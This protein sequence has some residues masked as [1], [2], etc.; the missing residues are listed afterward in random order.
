MKLL[1]E[2]EAEISAIDWKDI[3]L[4][5]TNASRALRK[6]GSDP[7][8]LSELLMHASKD[9][10]LNELSEHYDILDKIVLGDF[11]GTGMR[12]RLHVFA[13][14]YFD[15]P[16]N[17]RWPYA[18]TILSGSYLHRIFAASVEKLEQGVEV[19]ALPVC[20]AQQLKAG[21]SYAL[22]TDVVHSITAAPGTISMIL[23]GPSQSDRFLVMDRVSNMSWWQYGRANE[24]PAQIASKRMR[25]ESFARAIDRVKLA[26]L[27]PAD[28]HL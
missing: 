27:V 12:L 8:T 20:Q 16:H 15:R 2:I 19:S 6:I 14:G 3:E 13:N 26:G 10:E 18:S 25:P 9:A 1:D 17:H 28:Y 11:K 21:D 24:S 4:A 23:R 5:Y 7:H 22:G